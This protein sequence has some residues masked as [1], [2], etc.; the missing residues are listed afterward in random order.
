[1]ADTMPWF[2]YM[3]HRDEL[4][5]FPINNAAMV[6]DLVLC[7]SLRSAECTAAF[8]AVD[9]QH[10]WPSDTGQLTYADVPLRKG[11]LHLSAPH[12]YAKSLESMMPMRRGMSFLNVGSGTGY[13]NSIVSELIGDAAE[14]H[15]IDIHPE[16]VSHANSC[17]Q[18]HGKQHIAFTVGNV[19]QLD[20]RETMRYDRI[21]VGACANPRSKY[22]Y[23][24][25]E[26]GGVLVGP[27]QAG[28]AQ[29]LRRVTR[30]TETRFVVESLG[31]VQFATL[32]EP[33]PL[34][35]TPTGTVAPA[36]PERH[37]SPGDDED[38]DDDGGVADTVAAA[39]ALGDAG[40]HLGVGLPGVPF[41]F[42]IKEQPWTPARSWLYPA[43]FRSAVRAGLFG[44]TG[45][46]GL[47]SLPAEIWVKHIFPLCARR[48]F[49][50]G[51]C[52]GE[53]ALVPPAPAGARSPSCKDD[54]EQSDCDG[55][56]TRAST[57]ASTG[58]SPSFSMEAAGHAETP[59]LVE[60]FGG[61]QQHRIGTAGDPDGAAPD[62][63]G[64]VLFSAEL[65]RQRLGH[66]A[67]GRRRPRSGHHDESQEDDS[68]DDSIYDS[69]TEDDD[70]EAAE[71]ADESEEE[72][73]GANEEQGT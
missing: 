7:G 37:E 57:R 72:E 67:R 42:A 27:F 49:E 41:T 24:L 44:R 59:V 15:G 60:I 12:I 45:D 63:R 14:N 16:T 23:D 4:R 32:V 19:Y 54:S 71:E 34:R 20:V 21:Y 50:P 9:R 11:S 73:M 68:E 39:G 64:R 33:P 55:G 13:F 43:S 56:S 3:A 38:D 29:Q 25:L 61:G 18:R 6:E 52:V 70:D 36:P 5:G 53:R 69:G 62:E 31:S 22:L 1:M 65:L 10:Y 46:E 2:F 26:V 66:G 48:W 40:G 17:C 30:Q 47:P 51:G 35:P 58:S 8:Q 28:R